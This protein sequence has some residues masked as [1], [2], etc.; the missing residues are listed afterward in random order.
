MYFRDAHS[1]SSLSTPSRY[2][3]MTGRYCFR[4]P[5]KK[6]VLNGYGAPLI[7]T[8]RPTIP[9]MLVS[10]G[11]QTAIFGKWH[12]GLG[13]QTS[14]SGK[15]PT[16]ETV[17]FD[18]SLTYSPNDAGFEES[19]VLPASLD[20]PPY[21]FVS[22]HSVED[23][24]IVDVA[25]ADPPPY[26]GH[27][28]RAGK[29][30]ES[31]SFESCLQNLTDK[32]LDYIRA[33]SDVDK[34]FFVYMPLTAPHTPWLPTSQFKGGSNAGD[35]GDFVLNV[36]EVVGKVT[37]LLDSLHISDNTIVIFAS[38]NGADWNP[39]DKKTYP[40]LSNFI[41]RGRKSDI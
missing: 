19:Y 31:F 41:W 2:G 23:Q 32:G 25:G 39:S 20:M 3:I 40:H 29:A 34:P 37:A 17:A 24:N 12:L 11:Y 33:H 1:E 36:D 13:W 22:N 10:E 21:V 5:L 15:A 6:G 14:V 4:G 7:E 16:N 38:D 8:T 30:S 35:Y 9:S 28:W 26:R 27:L 18:K